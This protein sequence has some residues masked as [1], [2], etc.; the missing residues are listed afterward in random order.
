MASKRPSLFRNQNFS[1]LKDECLKNEKLFVDEYFPHDI[2]DVYWLRPHEI[3]KEPRFFVDG[4]SRCDVVQ[5]QMG[6]CWMVVAMAN[7]TMNKTLFN[8]VVPADQSFTENYTGMFRFRIWQIGQWVEVV[9]DDRIPTQDGKPLFVQSKQKNEFWSSLLEKAYAK[10]YGSYTHLTGG[11][12]GEAM[13]DFTGGIVET[14]SLSPVPSNLEQILINSFNKSSFMCV[15][16]KN[17]PSTK[18][19]RTS[20][21]LVKGHAYSITKVQYVTHSSSFNLLKLLFSA[22]KL[23]LIRMRN[24]WGKIEWNGAWSDSSDEWNSIE[25]EDRR[26]IGLVSENDGEFWMSISDF[27]NNFEYIDICHLSPSIFENIDAVKVKKSWENYLVKDQWTEGEDASGLPSISNRPYHNEN[28]AGVLQQQNW[29]EHTFRGEWIKDVNAGGAS[30]QTTHMNPKFRITLG[31]T[32]GDDDNLCTVIVALMQ[33]N[34]SR[35]IWH[36]IGFRTLEIDD[37]NT[38]PD[39]LSKFITDNL[40]NA[41]SSKFKHTR[42]IVVRYKW[43]PGVYCILPSTKNI[44]DEGQFLLRVFSEK[45]SLMEEIHE[46]NPDKTTLQD[47][48]QHHRDLVHPKK[49]VHKSDQEVKAFFDRR[50]DEEKEIGW[51]GLQTLLQFAM[52]PNAGIFS[53]S[54]EITFPKYECRSL[55]AMLDANRSGKLSFEEFQALWGKIRQWESVFLQCSGDS[56]YIRAPELRWALIKAGYPVSSS[57]LGNLVARHA[58]DEKRF[59]FSDFVMCAVELETSS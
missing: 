51:Q 9:V 24:P 49:L 18:E 21:G 4:A 36:R 6:N 46:I 33:K 54:K 14:L 15:F 26:K 12:F 35:K 43:P 2:P 44:N 40:T 55:I 27:A 16:M 23:L 20:E 37:S 31:E 38:T 22:E 28:D 30:P 8:H 52:S 3:C 45:P 39:A 48:S 47:D 57:T 10:V 29:V 42:E 13:V 56:D 17:N 41:Q 58:D 11:W 7:L 32:D 5:G 50:A 25:D 19:E 1:K 53:F 59:T 34:K